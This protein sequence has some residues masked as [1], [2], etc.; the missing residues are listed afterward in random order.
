MG[1]LMRPMQWISMVC[2]VLIGL[3]IF[4][5]WL[6]ARGKPLPKEDLELT[7]PTSAE[8]PAASSTS[9]ES[10]EPN[11]Q[12]AGSQPSADEGDRPAFSGR[13]DRSFGGR[14]D[15]RGRFGSERS[16]G[17]PDRP[18]DDPNEAGLEA[19]QLND[20]EM[21]SILQKLGEWTGKP[22]IPVNDEI[23]QTK[24]TIFS[25]AKVPREK[26][27][28]LLIAA[29]QARG[30]M[31]DQR[32]DMIL[33]KP[34]ASART[35]SV[36]TLS[37]DEPLA[38]IQEP[39]QI[40]EKWFQL[41]NYSPTQLAQIIGGLI[42]DYGYV[43]ADQTTGRV[44]VIETVENLRRIERIIRQLDVPES[45]QTVETI[46]K[47]KEAD[48]VE[49]VQ[50]LELLLT[51][52]SAQ[53]SRFS[54]RDRSRGRPGES[55]AAPSVV[56]DAGQIPIR[57][58]PVPKQRWILVRAGR[59]DLARI[60]EWV[61][62][63][64]LAEAQEASQ[65]VI[66]IRYANVTEV[67]R[68]VV[69][70]IQQ[71]PGTSLKA[72]VVV[73]A[74]PQTSQIVVFGSEEN[75]KLVERLIAEIDLPSQDLFET[76]TFT[77]Q[78]ADPDQIKAN[79]EGLYE[80]ESGTYNTYSYGRSSNRYSY[81]SVDPADVVKVVSYPTFKQVT[82][83]A[84]EKNMA[85]IAR[86][87]KEEWDIPM[88]IRQNQYRILDLENSDP[89]QM[90]NLL[91]QLFSEQ[92]DGTGNLRQLLFGLDGEDSKKKIVGSLYGMLTF[93]AVPDTKKIIVISKI[94]EAYDVIEAL[95]GELD[96][97]ESAEVPKVITL[98]YAD[99]EDLCDQLN[100]IMNE[101]GTNATI[102]RS[103][104]GLSYFDTSGES[105]STAATG[106]GQNSG[107]GSGG[108]SQETIQPWWNS[109]RPQEDQLPPSNLIGRVRFVPVQ[110]SKAI[111]A[112][113]PAEYMDDIT[114]MV[115]EL[116]RP[117]M[118]V[119]VKVVVMEVNH[120]S[121]TSLGTR[122]STDP[123]A[124]GE[125]GI[126][127]LDIFNKLA[128][129]FQRQSFSL[130]AGLNVDLM[131]DLL[132]RKANARILNQPTLWTK[133]NEEATFVKSRKIAFI[134][135]E[136]F[137]RTNP[138]STNRQFEFRD[139][140]V[141]LRVR[142]NITPQKRVN[143]IVHLNVSQLESEIVNTQ[144]TRRNLDT[145]TNL[146]VDDGQSIVMGGLLFQNDD[147]VVSKVPLLGDLPLLGGIFR[148]TETE[149]RNDELV[150]FITPYVIDDQIMAELPRDANIED[151]KHLEH[152][153]DMVHAELSRLQA[154]I[155]DILFDPNVVP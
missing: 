34:M 94:P 133:D 123:T 154:K 118:Q 138:D 38:R 142:P 37:V 78:Y 35:G 101:A 59:E 74:L 125:F 43:A 130:D 144:P 103:I 4:V 135:S 44:S 134:T 20:V 139:V 18:S 3:L 100:A 82:V 146:I 76:R 116:D 8:N 69:N 19:V 126:N 153:R 79:I 80:S 110:R 33:L 90:A 17:S 2:P 67:A 63:L 71:M 148:H 147:E 26:A 136:N 7:V 52:S 129:T 51:D 102:R 73:E 23:M 42:S 119:M 53:S 151:V 12:D 62:K 107:G 77:L 149:L 111:L 75:R 25:S 30:I 40:V 29:L 70:T 57:L 15:F 91:T 14:R 141:I 55:G 24:V 11:R 98:K 155:Y 96:S 68:M 145:I 32:A 13:G 115:E 5:G 97:R 132:V 95:V 117:G 152:P 113:A 89:V 83:I 45:S 1:V 46:I 122:F 128:A 54:G 127:S 56:L 31:V 99:S 28:S 60:E 108:Q 150:I 114:A 39:S 85:K 105:T 88:N 131:I 72:N 84:S 112:L 93:E 22:V 10:R 65:Q 66:P 47:L 120:S 64:D 86:Q 49:V 121:M 143:M 109:Q 140:G 61:R 87:I 6:S 36:P 104:R 9:S 137:D 81:R 41:T 27:L 106:S 50:V 16:E 48:P 58:I 92:Q 124:F 21:R